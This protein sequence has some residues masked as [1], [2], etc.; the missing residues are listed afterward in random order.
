M[1]PKR[2]PRAERKAAPARPQRDRRGASRADFLAAEAIVTAAETVVAAAERKAR[3]NKRRRA[4]ADDAEGDNGEDSPSEDGDGTRRSDGSDA[5]GD[6]DTT[7]PSEDDFKSLL[8][9]L[10]K[11]EAGSDSKS[12]KRPKR[13]RSVPRD[14]GSRNGRP[15]SARPQHS[16]DEDSDIEVTATGKRRDVLG[17]IASKAWRTLQREGH[18]TITGWLRTIPELGV[19][20]HECE[21]L[22]DALDSFIVDDLLDMGGSEGMERLFRRLQGVVIGATTGDWSMCIA[23]AKT[24]KNYSLIRGDDFIRLAKDA[25]AIAASTA[26]M[27]H[28]GGGGGGGGAR[29]K[30]GGRGRGVNGGGGGKAM[31]IKAPAAPPAKRS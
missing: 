6:D 23:L 21:A 7:K 27:A 25:K 29:K 16:S 28:S 30:R 17:N 31:P 11:L 12:G 14:H 8:K 1:G 15:R 22:A 26:S 4:A 13:P 3:A 24:R 19:H 5:E 10:A 9:R 2:R 20:Q 18:T